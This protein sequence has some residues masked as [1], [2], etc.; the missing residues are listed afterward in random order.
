[1]VTYESFNPVCVRKYA[2][3]SQFLIPNFDCQ[4]ILNKYI[5]AIKY[6]TFLI[7]QGSTDLMIQQS[8]S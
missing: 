1:M 8:T 5:N 2:A 4:V 6:S 3:P 7:I